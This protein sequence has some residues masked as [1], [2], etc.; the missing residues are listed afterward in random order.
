MTVKAATAAGRWVGVCGGMAGDP[1]G[2]MI[3]A[4]LGVA[5]LFVVGLVVLIRFIVASGV[6]A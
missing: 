2:A 3:L 5:A 4:G 1:K 6:A